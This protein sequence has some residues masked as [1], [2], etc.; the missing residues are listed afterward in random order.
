MALSSAAHKKKL[1]LSHHKICTHDDSPTM[2]PNN[3]RLANVSLRGLKRKL[4]IIEQHHNC[5][6]AFMEETINKGD[7]E[8][9]P[10]PAAIKTVCHLPHHGMHHLSKPGKLGVFNS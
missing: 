5:Y 8:L 9:A 7:A 3:K 1:S 10:M 2:L 6:R 4:K